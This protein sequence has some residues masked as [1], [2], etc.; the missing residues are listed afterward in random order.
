VASEL[1]KNV[2]VLFVVSGIFIQAGVGF[3][4]LAFFL[5]FFLIFFKKKRKKDRAPRDEFFSSSRRFIV[6]ALIA[7]AIAAGVNVLLFVVIVHRR[8]RYATSRVSSSHVA[9][10]KRVDY[11]LKSSVEAPS[12]YKSG[13]PSV[14]TES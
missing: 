1:C 14:D 4:V 11:K 2:N 12:S 5:H 10:K 6:S 13:N 3:C 9:G 7:S 8:M